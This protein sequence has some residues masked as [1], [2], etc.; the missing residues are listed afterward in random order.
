MGIFD[1]KSEEDKG[2]Q[3]MEIMERMGVSGLINLNDSFD[4]IFNKELD[5]EI[6]KSFSFFRR[7]T[8]GLIRTA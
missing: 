4:R 2:K 6:G 8:N 1:K 7:S 3:D 5:L